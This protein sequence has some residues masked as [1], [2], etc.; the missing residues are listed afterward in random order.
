MSDRRRQPPNRARH[1]QTL[2]EFALLLPMLLVLFLGVADFGRVFQAGIVTEAAARNA[3]E[4]AAVE[5]LRSGPPSTPGDVAFYE[6]L[7]RIAAQAACTES[8][9]LPNTTY[10]PDDPGT[11]GVDEEACPGMPVIAVCVQDGGD[12]ICGQTAPGYTGIVPGECNEITAGWDGASGGTVGS[13]SVEVRLCYRFTT[14]FNLHLSLPLGWGISI[15]DIYL[16][17]TRAFM[18]DCPPGDPA[19]SC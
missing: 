11:T 12:P 8:R 6:N 15:G 16:Q 2:V 13:H 18:V 17:R 9:A 14:L 10:V 3:A 7:H 5:R 1:G 19:V 4:A